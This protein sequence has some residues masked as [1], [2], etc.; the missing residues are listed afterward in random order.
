MT[1]LKTYIPSLRV[2]HISDQKTSGVRAQALD[3]DGNLIQ[4]FVFD[5]SVP[6]ELYD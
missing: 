3:G 4:D 6:G 2:D 1:E 5:K